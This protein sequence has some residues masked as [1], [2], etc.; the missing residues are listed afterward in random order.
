[1]DTVGGAL[2]LASAE[3]AGVLGEYTHRVEF[4]DSTS[5]VIIYGP[6]G[7]G[8][9]KFLEIIDSLSQL[10]TGRLLEL[11]FDRARLVYADG[12]TFAVEK[13]ETLAEDGDASV[14]D[15]QLAVTLQLQGSPSPITWSTT[16]S[17]ALAFERFLTTETTWRK[18]GQGQW[19]D[20]TD[21]EIATTLELESRYSRFRRFALDKDHTEPV[22]ELISAFVGALETHLIETQRLVVDRPIDPRPARTRPRRLP[23]STIVQYAN[24]MKNLLSRTLATNSKITQ[25]LDRTFP[26]RMLSQQGSSAASEVEIRA[27]YD[28]QTDFRARLARI[29]LIGLEAELSLP[30]RPLEESEVAMLDLYLQDADTK[31]ASFDN[32]LQ[33]AELLQQIINSRLLRKTLAVDSHD[34]LSVRRDSDHHV[35]ELDSLSS[36]EQHEIILMFNLLFEVQ[37]GSLVMIDEPE[38]SLHVS[39]QT[40]FVSDVQRIADL[41]G[42]QFIVA[43]HSPQ[44]INTWWQF[45]QQLGPAG[46]EL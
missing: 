7:V 24:E 16:A 32:V 28:A 14:L 42:F 33:K 22:P 25:Q 20:D 36:G 4:S 26:S 30:E 31:L 37:P 2:K 39:W 12:T 19:R 43:T 27:R 11:P 5:F 18:T 8:K 9:T 3:V 15:T 38:I 41:A 23:Q 10:Q 21:D 17:S 45:A 13:V 44:V 35:I 46:A 40:N 29:A 6:N 1:M 34:G